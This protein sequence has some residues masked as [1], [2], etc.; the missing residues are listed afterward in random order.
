MEAFMVIMILSL[1]CLNTKQSVSLPL[2]DLNTQGLALLKLR[3]RVVSDPFGALS[4]WNVNHG[5]IDPCS[6]FGVHCSQAKLVTLNLNGLCLQGTIGPEIG[7][8]THLKSIIL[9]NNSFS[10]E[11]PKEMLQLEELE[12]V[13]LGYNN[14][15]GSFPSDLDTNLSLTTLLLDNN[16]YLANLTPEVYKLKMISESRVN[17]ELLTGGAPTKAA[18]ISRSSF[19]Y[20]RQLLQVANAPSSLPPDSEPF[21]PSPLSVSPSPSIF[22]PPSSSPSPS[23][24]PSASPE[25]SE[26]ANPPSVVS[27]PPNSTWDSEPSPSPISNQKSSETKNHTVIIWSTVGSFSFLVLVSAVV[28]VCFRNTKVVTVKPW[29]IGLS[30]QLQKAFVTGVPSLKRAELE[31]ACEDFSNIIG[32]LPEGTVYKG[33]LSSGIEIAVVSTAV[34]SSQNWSKHMEVQFRNKLETLSRVNHKNFVNLIGYCE[35][36]KPFTRMMVFEYA[37]NGTLFEHLHIREAEHLDWGMRMRIAM[38]I[39][40]CLEHIHQLTPPISHT[41]LQSS[42]ICL[43]ED[44]AAKISDLSLCNDIITPAKKTST[45]ATPPSACT[46]DNVYSYGVMLFELITGTIPNAVVDN[47]IFLADWGKKP[48]KDVVDPTLSSLTEEE[49][50]KWFKVIQECVNSDPEKRPS[51]REVTARLKEVTAMEPDGAT[52]QS[53]PLWWAEL[54]ILSGD[55]S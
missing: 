55:S 6:W 15:S 2:N 38:G 50:E 22:I 24:S 48:L 35:E 12:V 23:P 37:P 13:D 30:G 14:F 31:A 28:F 5:V 7:K 51:M 53:S 29:P 19:W 17:E 34:T 32:S 3:E 20:R 21:T 16:D 44:Y 49:I 39:A 42:S 33:T 25:I 45:I 18:C 26:P 8:L 27:S 43:T 36:K 1:F 46:K 4:N 10:G 9:R 11:I 52:P 47:G 41:N 40:Y 54:E